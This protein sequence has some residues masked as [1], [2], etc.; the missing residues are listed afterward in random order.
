MTT[1]NGFT[2]GSEEHIHGSAQRIGPVSKAI[3][4]QRSVRIGFVGDLVL[5]GLFLDHARAAKLD[6]LHPFRLLNPLL[7]DLDVVV[8]N[9]E[10][11]LFE[12]A[13]RRA[14]RGVLL[15][16]H[17]A[18]VE[19]LSRFNRCVCVLGNNHILDYGAEG[20]RRTITRLQSKSIAVVGAGE[21]DA[22]ARRATVVQADGWSLCCLSYTSDEPHVGSV[23]A[24]RNSPGCASWQDRGRALADVSAARKA[25]HVVV[26]SLHWG[27]EF[28][29]HPTHEQVAFARDLVKAGAKVVVGHHPHVVQGVEEIA[30]GLIA[31]SLGH[32]FVPPFRATSGRLRLPTSASREFVLL[33]CEIAVEGPM[34]W[35]LH[36]GRLRPDYTLEPYDA[37]GQAQFRERVKQLSAPLAAE[38]YV[39]FWRAYSARRE[40]QLKWERMLGKLGAWLTRPERDWAQG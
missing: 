2:T 38:D 6:L 15:S 36:G 8:V 17:E 30:G 34:N 7:R 37:D 19:C 39:Q 3:T 21:D 18:V 9:L 5:G 12:G 1:R 26:V 4:E 20:L 28:H 40:R 33:E 11:P 10:G 23:I 13:D 32:F 31:Y 25:G 22:A 27:H 29:Q 14:G 35:R 24:T 16:N